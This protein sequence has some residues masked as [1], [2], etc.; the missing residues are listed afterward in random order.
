MVKTIEKL[1][2][3]VRRN[4]WILKEYF[5]PKI[6]I[7]LCEYFQCFRFSDGMCVF[8]D[9]PEVMEKLEST[10]IMFMRSML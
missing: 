8:L 2:V 3:Y 7:Q 6:L 5:S 9:N 1:E 4:C 10:E